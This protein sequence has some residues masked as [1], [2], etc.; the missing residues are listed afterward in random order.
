MDP[1]YGTMSMSARRYNRTSFLL[2]VDISVTK[3]F[4]S[5]TYIKLDVYKLSENVYKKTALSYDKKFCDY[6]GPNQ[7][8]YFFENEVVKKKMHFMDRCPVKPDYY[9]MRD[10]D[11]IALMNVQFF[12]F[13]PLWQA[14][15]VANIGPKMKPI[16]I[17]EIYFEIMDTP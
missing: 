14:K 15:I 16:L 7:K 2:N 17:A 6:I 9:W 12:S 3:S 13:L 5:D 11:P 1:D 10:L 8:K 4:P